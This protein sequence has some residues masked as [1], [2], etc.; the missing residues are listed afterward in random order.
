MAE[1]F[2][3]PAL[4]MIP[5]RTEQFKRPELFTSVNWHSVSVP[6]EPEPPLRTA[7][8]ILEDDY[9]MID[10]IINNGHTV[11]RNWRRPRRRRAEPRRRKTPPGSD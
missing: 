3:V 8:I 7:K 4:N 11:R 2:A 1:V 6:V 9:G 10:G 5:K